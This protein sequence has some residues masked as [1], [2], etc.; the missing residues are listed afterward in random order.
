MTL[1]QRLMNNQQ[2]DEEDFK[3]RSMQHGQ[4]LHYSQAQ[5]MIIDPLNKFNNI[6]KSSYNFAQI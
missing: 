5:L 3:T 4:S 2:K 6:G 1:L